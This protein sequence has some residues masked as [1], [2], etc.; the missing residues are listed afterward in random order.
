M[1][2]DDEL[3]AQPEVAG[4]LR[5]ALTQR[6]LPTALLFAGP[7]GAGKMVAARWLAQALNCESGQTEPCGQ[8]AACRKIAQQQHPDC[9]WLGGEESRAATISIEDVRELIRRFS[10]R[11]HEGR[12]KVGVIHEA[13]RLSAEAA[14]A[15]LKLLEEPPADTRLILT[16]EQPD[17]L[18]PTIRSRCALLRFRPAPTLPG[19]DAAQEAQRQAWLE[20]W[21]S[22]RE[23][24]M[25]ERGDVEQWL[26]TI[27]G[28]HREQYYSANNAEVIAYHAAVVER[29][30]ALR[31]ALLANGNPKLIITGALAAAR[32]PRPF[33]TLMVDS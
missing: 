28:W 30:L 7:R 13:E 29:L 5:R 1:S 32:L 4:W 20:E 12:V 22:G 26:Q 24:T 15:L 33:A 8:C 9:A 14:S 3:T 31:E 2:S 27:I 16:T 23:P 25:T 10:Y 21:Q 6:R 19:V 11:P 18:L 17:Q